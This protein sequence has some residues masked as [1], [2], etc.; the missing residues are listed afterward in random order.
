MGAFRAGYAATVFV[1]AGAEITPVVGVAAVVAEGAAVTAAA[2]A[3]VAEG[4]T[5]A[6]AGR[7]VAVDT[8]AGAAGEQALNKIARAIRTIKKKVVRFIK[9]ISSNG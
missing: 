6:V 5:V 9:R 8:T 7:V 3:L 1:G 2:L 4:A